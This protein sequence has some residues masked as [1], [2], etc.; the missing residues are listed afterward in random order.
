MKKVIDHFKITTYYSDGDVHETIRH[1]REGLA[2]CIKKHLERQKS[3][4]FYR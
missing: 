4:S 2:A 3:C 1:T